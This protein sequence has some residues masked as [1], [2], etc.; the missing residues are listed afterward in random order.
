MVARL[1]RTGYKTE[2]S[3]LIMLTI[4]YLKIHNEACLDLPLSMLPL[5]H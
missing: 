5:A 4:R 3:R 2:S 1:T